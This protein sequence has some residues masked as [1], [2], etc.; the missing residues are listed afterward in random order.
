MLLFQPFS[1]I[2]TV[3]PFFTLIRPSLVLP[4][5]AAA[6]ATTTTTALLSCSQSVERI[7]LEFREH[8]NLVRHV[9]EQPSHANYFLFFLYTCR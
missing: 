6:I 1:Q 9:W 3:T 8:V 4:A 5:A 7:S 2:Q